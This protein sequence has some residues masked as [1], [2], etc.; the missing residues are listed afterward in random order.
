MGCRI[1][2]SV[3]ANSGV[4]DARPRLSVAIATAA[5]ERSAHDTADRKAEVGHDSR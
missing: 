1:T 4:T 3:T 2:A 5:G